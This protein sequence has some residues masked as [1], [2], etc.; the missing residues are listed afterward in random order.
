MHRH[1]SLPRISAAVVAI[2]VPL[3]YWLSEL[4]ETIQGGDFTTFR[5]VLT[6]VGEAGLP[7]AVLGIAVVRWRSLGALGLWGA[8]L[9]AYAFVFFASTVVYALADHVATW[10]E[11]RDRFGVWLVVHGAVMVVGGLLLGA[12]IVRARQL[13]VWIGVCLAV[14]VIAVAATT[15]QGS[16]VRTIAA[17]L[18][19]LALVGLGLESL[20]SRRAVR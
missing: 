7:F 11:V 4:V 19:T 12:A 16:A 15:T 1:Q 5:L 17:A 14:G 13:P 2:V 6:Y 10:S 3:V 8:V 18:P 20:P 9:Y